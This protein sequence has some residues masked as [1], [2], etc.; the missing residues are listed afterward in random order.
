[1]S[2][3][4]KILAIVKHALENHDAILFME[5]SSLFSRMSQTE[6]SID[7]LLSTHHRE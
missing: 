1:M 5:L 6:A 2:T 7:S 3:N 4:E